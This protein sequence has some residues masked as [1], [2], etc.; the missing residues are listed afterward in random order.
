MP[1][2]H[3]QL[4]IVRP[5][6]AGGC[7]GLVG[8]N[9]KYLVVLVFLSFTVVLPGCDYKVHVDNALTVMT[10]NMGD[11][12]LPAPTLDQVVNIVRRNGVPDI[13]FV[14]D[15]PW[16]ITIKDLADALGFT[17]FVSGRTK[18][19]PHHLGILSNVP[20]CNAKRIH[21]E[22]QPDFPRPA[23]LCAEIEVNHKRIVLC[24]VHLATLRSE[25]H[26][27]QR[28]G[29]SPLLSLLKVLYDETFS[30]TP[31]SRSVEKL[32]GWI[33]SKKNDAVIIGG[34]FN[35]FPLSRPIRA[36]GRDFDDAL[37][38]SLDYFVGTKIKAERALDPSGHNKSL[39]L[40]L[41]PRIDYIFHS[42]NIDC[43]KAEVIRQTAGDHYPIRAVLGLRS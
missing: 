2:I 33:G 11:D 26:R 19:S 18:E 10:Y 36:M 40:P 35:T 16:A 1:K 9:F 17:H 41:N 38:P 28:N 39:E 29:K 5:E 13:L 21:F 22:P 42:E 23:A 27:L 24:S 31:H 20:L 4:S 3:S 12:C 14:Q 32:L 34:D 15:V 6:C 30:D 37:W 8:G 7:C 25:L 43:L